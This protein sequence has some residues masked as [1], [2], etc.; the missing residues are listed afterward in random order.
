MI[1][2]CKKETYICVYA[3][4]LRAIILILIH[5]LDIAVGRQYM[6]VPVVCANPATGTC[7]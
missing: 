6:Q 1:R 3:Y 2:K 7:N 5:L 4:L